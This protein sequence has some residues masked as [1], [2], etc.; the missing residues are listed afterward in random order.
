LGEEIMKTKKIGEI[1]PYF[2]E[3]N[4]IIPLSKDWIKLFQKIP[5]F[6]IV[7]EKTGKLVLR[8]KDELKEVFSFV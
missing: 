5:E 4:L 3:D 2:F 6:E 7:L 8:T 1:S